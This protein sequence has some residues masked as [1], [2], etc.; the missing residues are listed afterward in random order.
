MYI[1]RRKD[2]SSYLDKTYRHT[3]T[4][5]MVLLEQDVSSSGDNSK[6]RHAEDVFVNP[7]PMV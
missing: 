6:I 4:R 5:R 7:C 3:S 1:F 2:V